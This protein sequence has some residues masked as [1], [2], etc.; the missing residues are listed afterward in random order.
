VARN[1]GTLGP[2]PKRRRSIAPHPAEHHRSATC[3][4][5]SC[6]SDSHA[7]AGSDPAS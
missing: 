3:S 2:S 7:A 4:L 1:D 5:Q 6:P